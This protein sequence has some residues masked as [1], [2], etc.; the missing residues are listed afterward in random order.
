MSLS[1][2]GSRSGSVASSIT[3]NVPGAFPTVQTPISAGRL[4]LSDAV[5]AR[6]AEYVQSKT[7]RL[8]V[9]TWNTAAF[10]GTEKDI[11]SWFVSGQGVSEGLSGVKPAESTNVS[12]ED[13]EDVGDQ[14]SRFEVGERSV[15]KRDPGTQRNSKDVDLYLLGLQEI[16]DINSATE[17]LRPFTDP[18][19]ATKWKNEIT[20][21]L[22]ADY[23]LVSEQQLIGLLLL[24]YASPSVADD[25]DSV[26]TTSVGTGLMGVMGNKG[27]VTTRLILGDATRLVFINAHLAAGA[28]KASLERR[29]WDYNQVM[30]RTKF[31]P[32]PDRT[33]LQQKTGELIDD[34]DFAFWV[35]DLNYRL[36]GVPA[37]DIR[38]LLMLHT[39]NEYD[40]AQ[41]S[42][43][44]IEHEI[45]KSRR[46]SSDLAALAS[47]SLH[48]G[49]TADA[50]SPA[51]D[52]AS[53]QT[54]INSLISHDELHQQMKAGNAFHEGWQEG[55]VT[56]LPTYKYDPGSVGIFDS[57][58]KRRAPSWCDRILYRSRKH[59]LRYIKDAAEKA[60]AHDRDQHM[61][62]HGL[63]QASKDEDLLYDYDPDDDDDD[64][65]ETSNAANDSHVASDVGT[66]SD[67]NLDESL[68]L[69]S[70]MAHQRVLTSD[71]KPLH[72]LFDLKYDAIIPAKKAAVQQEVAREL[73]KVENEG[74]PSVTSQYMLIARIYCP[75]TF[76]VVIDKTRHS[77]AATTDEDAATSEGVYFGHVKFAQHKHRSLTVANTG[78]VSATLAFIDRPVERE[79]ESGPFPPW[80]RLSLEDRELKTSNNNI[81]TTFTLE[82]GDSCAV[83]LDVRVLDSALVSDLNEGTRKLDD[84][85]V[86][87]VENGRDHFIPIYGKW[88]Q[89][90]FSKSIDKLIRIPA[91]GLRRLQQQRPDDRKIDADPP[92]ESCSVPRELRRLTKAIEEL[93]EECLSQ[94]PAKLEQTLPAS[95]LSLGWP[96]VAQ[97]WT[98][99]TEQDRDESMHALCEDLDEA[100]SLAAPGQDIPTR[101]ELLAAF[102][103]AYLTHMRD[104]VITEAMWAQLSPALMRMASTKDAPTDDDRA[105]I[106]E[107]MSQSPPHNISFVL[108]TST[109]DRVTAQL[110]RLLRLDSPAGTVQKENVKTTTL[111]RIGSFRRKP[112]VEDPSSKAKSD[113]RQAI[114]GVFAEA[115][116]RS[117]SAARQREK[118][119][120]H[121]LKMRLVEMFL[122]SP[123][124]SH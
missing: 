99:T 48:I 77:D 83:E 34:A 33:G 104:G 18:G 113:M 124:E 115:M 38:R 9:G 94:P 114:A 65:E 5:Y 14:E 69:L 80:L 67:S 58:E 12:T 43:R 54:T 107:V 49:D 55:P 2:K 26:S 101:L 23:V 117:P 53:L 105:Q 22:P 62:K 35:G 59:R 95:R 19:A 73:D 86:L 51:S 15:P 78:S 31:E 111:G 93:T 84:I 66:K 71:H 11:G 25:I 44:K 74:R 64:Y 1:S 97:S 96:F 82:P 27:A 90:S 30:S 3:K 91:D 39:R 4:S 56:F 81:D 108:I 40:L 41:N 79:Q 45:E 37:D 118:T 116:C 123:S 110:S 121:I 87:R 92:V 98:L 52:P 75:L 68:Q 24:I 102:M 50:P 61:V 10:D 60:A 36:E 29:N 13:F 122:N 57:S 28:D 6:R 32:V 119:Q 85:L 76:L 42:S 7:I 16:I 8:K 21:T 120:T 46:A 109:L 20:R 47:E 17:A 89:S 88:Q 112:V 72:A 100:R 63:D 70:Y 103:I 106:Q